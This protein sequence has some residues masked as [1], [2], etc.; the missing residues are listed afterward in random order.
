MK[1]SDS[2]NRLPLLMSFEIYND[3]V[4]ESHWPSACVLH[5][6]RNV[7]PLSVSWCT[8]Q[9][10]KNSCRTYSHHMVF[11]DANDR[12]G[13]KIYSPRTRCPLLPDL[14]DSANS[15]LS[16][17]VHCAH[18]GRTADF[19]PFP[20]HLTSLLQY[21][22]ATRILF[23]TKAMKAFRCCFG[24]IVLMNQAKLFGC[25]ISPVNCRD[26][27]NCHTVETGL[28][29]HL[30]LKNF[31]LQ[32]DPPGLPGGS[33]CSFEESKYQI[34]GHFS[35]AGRERRPFFPL[36]GLPNGHRPSSSGPGQ[37]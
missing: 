12:T 14:V 18:V 16:P 7:Q 23:G 1:K 17:P 31:P 21:L 35:S 2:W 20:T 5:G 13:Q 37:S 25:G 29:D 3:S 19:Q 4:L 24:P 22:L 30:C 26:V 10:T 6:D 33:L 11:A 28:A 9:R 32:T 34:A 27:Q 36:A 8:R 15:K